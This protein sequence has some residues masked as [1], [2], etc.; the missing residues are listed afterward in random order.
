MY[1]ISLYFVKQIPKYFFQDAIHI[2]VDLWPL[3]SGFV[4]VCPLTT[5]LFL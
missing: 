1:V 2:L 5:I 3:C 4:E